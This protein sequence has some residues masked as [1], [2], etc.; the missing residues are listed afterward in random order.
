IRDGIGELDGRTGN[1]LVDAGLAEKVG[2][3]RNYRLTGEGTVR[4]RELLEAEGRVPP[5]PRPDP[6]PDPAPP[7]RPD[8]V[9]DPIP[10]VPDAPFTPSETERGLA[11]AFDFTDPNGD[12]DLRQFLKSSES[13]LP[14]V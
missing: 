14:M 10:E 7:P 5:P 11:E 1:A 12:M 8:P 4:A 13:G 3:G 9:P 2:A 6:V